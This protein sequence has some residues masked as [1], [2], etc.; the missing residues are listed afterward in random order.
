MENNT[1]NI[2]T[3]GI[4]L[5]LMLALV[6]LLFFGTDGRDEEIGDGTENNFGND[7]NKIVDKSPK[8]LYD[9]YAARAAEERR[10]IWKKTEKNF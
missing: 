9:I 5:A 10:M 8:R 6:C 2:F 1:V 7:N 3:L 4:V